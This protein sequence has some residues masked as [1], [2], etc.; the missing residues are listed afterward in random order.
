ML[1]PTG[2][3]EDNFVYVFILLSREER[4]DLGDGSIGTDPGVTGWGT[5]CLSQFTT[6][7][8]KKKERSAPHMCKGGL[9][10]CADVCVCVCVCV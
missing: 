9:T 8:Q 5:I 2:V 4:E 1:L 10:T 3:D 7:Q 6:L